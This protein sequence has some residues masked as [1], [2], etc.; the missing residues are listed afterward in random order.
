MWEEEGQHGTSEETEI[1]KG[2]EKESMAK[3]SE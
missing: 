2:T 1:G 3:T